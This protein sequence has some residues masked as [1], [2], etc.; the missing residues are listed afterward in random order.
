[1]SKKITCKTFLT[2]GNLLAI[3][4]RLAFSDAHILLELLRFG[5]IKGEGRQLQIEN[6]HI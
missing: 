2:V 6:L 4:G 3:L 5:L 1:L